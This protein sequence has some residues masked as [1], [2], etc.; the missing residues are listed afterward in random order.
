MATTALLKDASAEE[1]SE[2]TGE[3]FCCFKCGECTGWRG[4]G[5]NRLMWKSLCTVLLL[6][7]MGAYIWIVLD[8]LAL[9]FCGAAT[10]VKFLIEVWGQDTPTWAA[11]GTLFMLCAM[12]VGIFPYMVYAYGYCR[13]GEDYDSLASQVLGVFLFIFGSGLSLSYEVGRFRWKAKPENKGKLH[14]VGLA[15]LVIHPNYL[16]DLFTYSGWAMAVGTWCALAAPV[17]MVWSFAFVVIPNSDAYLASRYVDQFPDYAAKTPTLIPGLQ[18]T[19]ALKTLG[20][21]AFVASCY[22]SYLCGGVCG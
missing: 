5:T 13:Y 2:G 3:S 17:F 11:P 6:G 22:M 10:L 4:S 14:T 19:V 15:R 21:V 8:S 7:E 20:I 16:G 9:V 12:Y 1:K 18:S